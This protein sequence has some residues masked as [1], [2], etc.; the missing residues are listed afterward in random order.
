MSSDYIPRLRHELLRAGAAAPARRR[1]TRVASSLVPLATGAVAIAAVAL[2]LVLVWPTGERDETAVAPGADGPTLTY[3]VVPAD[4]AA[5]EQTAQVMRARLDAM[6]IDDVDVSVASGGAA[7]GFTASPAV[8]ADVAA[9]TQRGQVAF[10]DWERS[11]LGPGGRPAPADESVTGGQNAARGAGVTRAEAESRAA[12]ADGGRVVRG[13]DAGAE[14]WFALG[15][16]PALTDRDIERATAAVDVPTK[17]PVVAIDFT[18][19]GQ[20]A[21]TALTRE[22]AQRGSERAADGVEAMQANQHFAILIDDR[23]VSVPYI[24]FRVNPD[25]VDG[26]SGAQVSGGLTEEDARRT[27]TILTI[28]PL[29]AALLPPPG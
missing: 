28:G 19:P 1:R 26:S 11:V 25:G 14:S 6:D 13:L 4:A 3:R 12:N 21:F 7:L 23:I 10:Y 9:L 17:E 22:V 2:A 5:A 18:G 27:A 20:S 24:D 16:E 15:G 8:K 29:P